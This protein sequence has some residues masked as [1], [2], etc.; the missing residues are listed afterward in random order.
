M[1]DLDPT[2]NTP[3]GRQ[4]IGQMPAYFRGGR[5]E[6]MELMGYQ[7]TLSNGVH[8]RDITYQVQL[9]DGWV[10]ANVASRTEGGRH[11]VEGASVVPLQGDLRRINAFSLAR[12][13]AVHLLFLVL[14]GG[15]P[16]FMLA[17][18]VMAYR[19]NPGQRWRWVLL[20]VVG[21]GKWSLNWT[22]GETSFSAVNLQLLGSGM[23][24]PSSFVPWIVSVS[25]PAGA[26]W[27][28]LRYL[29]R[30]RADAAPPQATEDATPAGSPEAA[31]DAAPV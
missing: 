28:W 7:A 18:A 3:A 11:V 17:T 24:R 29:R 2:L 20:S 15:L 19:T 30:R 13:P 16:L 25:L 22:T 1:R 4:S 9:A 8:H 31:A 21:L 27:V 5:I 14:L 23:M 10:A 12:K 26:L 6:R